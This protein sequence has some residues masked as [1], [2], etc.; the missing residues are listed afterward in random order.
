MKLVAESRRWFRRRLAQSMSCSPKY[1][2]FPNIRFERRSARSFPHG[3]AVTKRNAQ[4]PHRVD[5]PHFLNLPLASAARGDRPYLSHPNTW[6]V[7]SVVAG[8][9]LQVVQNLTLLVI[10]EWRSTR[11]HHLELHR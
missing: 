8:V 1:G 4:E 5:S 11:L 2:I 3:R 10:R 7:E 6:A 9:A